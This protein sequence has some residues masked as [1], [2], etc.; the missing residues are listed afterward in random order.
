VR[1]ARNLLWADPGLSTA[2]RTARDLLWFDLGVAIAIVLLAL[3]A[4]RWLTT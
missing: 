3:G 1:P 4:Y 2:M